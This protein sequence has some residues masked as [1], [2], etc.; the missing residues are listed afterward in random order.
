MK[1]QFLVI[2]L[3]LATVLLI[4]CSEKRQGGPMPGDLDEHGCYTPANYSWCEAK[5]KCLRTWEENCT[6]ETANSETGIQAK[7]KEFCN[8]ENVGSVNICETYIEVNSKLLGGGAKYYDLNGTL[9]FSCPV[10]APDSMSKKCKEIFEGRLAETFK[11][12]KICPAEGCGECPQLVAPAPNWCNDGTV[13]AGVKNECGCQGPPKCIKA[14]TE[15]AKI[16][17]DGSAVGRVGPNCEF[18]PCPS[19]GIA[20]PASVFCKA[21]GGESKIITAQDGSQSGV[22]TLKDGTQCDEWAY[23]RGECPE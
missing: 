14:C 2:G 4:G 1:T 17:P 18:A 11:C 8:K 15:E 13:V 5:Q 16:C 21:Q 6:A 10:V 12:E 23:Y 7:A 9:E 19:V 3:V 20:N 22:C